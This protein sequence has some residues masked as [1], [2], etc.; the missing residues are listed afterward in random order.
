MC[1]ARPGPRCSNTAAHRYT[2]AV[3]YYDRIA[4]QVN[5][6]REQGRTVSEAL[7]SKQT[8]SILR[9]NAAQ[10]VFWATPAG[11]A[12]LETL[13]ETARSERQRRFP[14]GMDNES[15]TPPALEYRRLKNAEDRADKRR[16]EGIRRRANAYA[17]MR[18]VGTERRGL[19]A[20]ATARG[21]NIGPN[22]H[23]LTQSSAE[24]LRNNMDTAGISLREWS[25]DDVSRAKDWVDAGAARDEYFYNRRVRPFA[26]GRDLDG[27]RIQI[28]NTVRGTS[29]QSKLVRLNTPDGQVVEAR[30]DF[31]LTQN[32]QGTYVVSMRSTV[33]SSWEDASPI[34][35]T[36][37]QVGHLLKPDSK[38]GRA[39]AKYVL[40]T[41]DNLSEANAKLE[42]AKDEFK[43]E[44][45][46]ALMARDTLTSRSR[47]RSTAL[48]TRGFAIWH[49][50]AQP[51][52]PSN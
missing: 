42:A 10:Q 4:E 7:K 23:P 3:N 26:H 11:Q 41:A 24:T 31:H 40:A 6:Q 12:E 52:E 36:K 49:R 34:D 33:A 22:A 20:Q 48:Q 19:R 18:L 51:E 39:Q 46:T 5:R 43:A 27:Q 38:A 25:P 44:P 9:L 1:R 16:A 45:V 15:M 17:D 30:H 50:Y 14:L 37:Q 21:G 29:P 32:D 8:L 47:R 2:K 35:D 28:G 13:A